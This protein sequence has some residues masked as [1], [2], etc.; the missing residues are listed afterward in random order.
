MSSTCDGGRLQV[1]LAFSDF[2]RASFVSRH[3]HIR[4]LCAHEAA[5]TRLFRWQE[6]N[7]ANCTGGMVFAF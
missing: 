7:R 1:T 2:F 5:N 4:K 3:S 6:T